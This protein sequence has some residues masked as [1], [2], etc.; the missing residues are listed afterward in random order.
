LIRNAVAMPAKIAP[1]AT[2]P[3][4]RPSFPGVMAIVYATP[5]LVVAAQGH[6]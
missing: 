6:P 4:M 1:T 3:N 5:R 2:R